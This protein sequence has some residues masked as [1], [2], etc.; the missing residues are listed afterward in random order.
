MKKNFKKGL[1]LVALMGMVVFLSACGRTEPITAESTG[2]WDGLIVRNFSLIIIW[3]SNLLGGSYGLGI[4]AFTLLIRTL[5]IPLSYWQQKS[6]SRMSDLQPKI[7]EIEAKYP[8][9]DQA[10]VEKRQELQAQLMEENNV[11]PMMGCL[12]T[13]AQMPILIA[14]FQ[15]I[16]RTPVFSE[17]TFLWLDLAHP[18]PYY[19]LPILA[20]LFAFINTKLTTMATAQTSQTAGMS[21][22][23]PIMIFVIS[24][25][26]PSAIA[27]YFATSN[28]FSIVQTL[29]LNNPFKKKRQ[30][31]EEERRQKEAEDRRQKALKKARKTGRS[32]KK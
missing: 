3:L 22:I 26:L 29:L 15:A 32:T 17:Q 21:Y 31:E 28:A 25:R 13:L 6:M 12:P 18:D 4:I 8:G 19:I 20:A 24:F 11:N 16:S 14:L 9:N 5:L 27:I 23:M 30:Q 10:T 1:L 7:Q 2:L